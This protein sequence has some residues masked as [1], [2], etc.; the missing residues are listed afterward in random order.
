MD[1]KEITIC[2]KCNND[3]LENQNSIYCD[4]CNTWLH[5]KCINLTK[6][7]LNLLSLSSE[8]WY[9][10]FCLKSIFPFSSITKSQLLALAFHQYTQ[11]SLTEKKHSITLAQ[12]SGTPNKKCRSCRKI[13]EPTQNSIICRN[14]NTT[15]H[16]KCS[17]LSKKEITTFRHCNKS[18]TCFPV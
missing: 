2:T 17:L 6:K 13:V 7:E 14:C 18:W 10:K 9:C 15:I 5:A 1:D 4:L 11:L 3:V 12:S 16:L 8:T